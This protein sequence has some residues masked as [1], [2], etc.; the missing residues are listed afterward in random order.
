MYTLRELVVLCLASYL[1]GLFN[2]WF[3]EFLIK[4]R[5]KEHGKD[6]TNS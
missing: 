6:K 4:T 5:I 2:N 3:I 1:V